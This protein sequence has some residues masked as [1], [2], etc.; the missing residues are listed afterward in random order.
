MMFCKKHNYRHAFFLLVI[1]FFVAR[2]AC[3][4]SAV[5]NQPPSAPAQPPAD[6]GNAP[7]FTLPELNGGSITL[8]AYKGSVIILDFWA[9]WCPP[10]REEIPDFVQLYHQYRD[11]GLVIIG[12]SLDR[13][14]LSAVRPFAEAQGIDYPVALGYG[15]TELMNRYGGINAIPTTFLIDQKGNIAEKFIGYRSRDVFE[16]K[17]KN[18]LNR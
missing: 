16:N 3:K 10:C 8:S 6:W 18:L 14:G 17:I 2:A 15:E 7:D 11:Q 4:P 12:V 5:S 9:T 13:D 1:T